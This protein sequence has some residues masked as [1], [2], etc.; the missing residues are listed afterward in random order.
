[1]EEELCFHRSVYELQISYMKSLFESVRYLRIHVRI[2]VRHSFVT[3][4]LCCCELT[5]TEANYFVL[6]I[7]STLCVCV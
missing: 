7:S 3:I 1:M 4:T 2:I 5:I 6:C